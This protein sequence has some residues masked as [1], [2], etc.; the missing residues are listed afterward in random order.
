MKKIL[1]SPILH[2]IIIGAVAYVLFIQL[3][4]RSKDAIVI[5][6]QIIDALVRNEQSLIPVEMKEE[7]KQELIKNFIDEEVML[8]DAYKR[9]LNKNDFRVR[10]RLLTLMRSSLT[11]IIP[12]QSIAQLRAYYEENGNK[13]SSEESRSFNTAF[14]DL[15]SDKI[16]KDGE[17][18]CKQLENS[19][20]Y[21]TGEKLDKEFRLD[22]LV[23]NEIIIEIKAVEFILPVH[24]AQIIS[25]LK[26]A[27]KSLGFL[28][29]FNVPLLKNGFKR[30]VNNF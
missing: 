1:K 2:F 8:K 18:F 20:I 29:N 27:D 19:T 3:F 30:F 25:Y 24:E 6:P 9:D 15:N 21:Y 7:R 14:F 23:A 5:T 16:P 28:I 11:E 17:A 12:E 10:K 4:P 13:F 26:L 22:L